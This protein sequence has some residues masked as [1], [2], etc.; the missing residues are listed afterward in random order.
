MN[1]FDVDGHFSFGSKPSSLRDLEELQRVGVKTV[2]SLAIMP[3]YVSDSLKARGIEHF[4]LLPQDKTRFVDYFR[5][6][7]AQV[8]K[9][10]EKI[11]VHCALG[12]S[13]SPTVAVGYL[14]SKGISVKDAIEQISRKIRYKPLLAQDEWRVFE[15]LSASFKLR[16]N[17]K[18]NLRRR[19]RLRG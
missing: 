10:S 17:K 4:V 5:K 15:S 1:I 19:R 6:T 9:H 11:F 18:I 2:I 3:K 12:Q 8:L 16:N 14:V 7:M 13:L